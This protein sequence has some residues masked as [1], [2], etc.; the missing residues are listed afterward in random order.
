MDHSIQFSLAH[1][2]VLDLAPPAVARVAAEA[3]FDAFGLRLH[4]VLPGELAP[5][6]FGD[7]PM[8]RELLAIIADTG[9]GMFD[10][11]A[12]RLTRTSDF[13]P[14]HDTLEA[15]A[16]FGAKHALVFIDESDRK[17]AADLLARFTDIAD[18]YGIAP[19]LE[20]MP[21]LGINSL[22][23]ALDVI[24]LA[25]QSSVGLL[26]DCLHVCRTN[27]PVA[28]LRDLDPALLHY[29]QVC[30]APRL[31]PPTL[32]AIADEARNRRMFPG[33]G[34]LPI[35]EIVSAL[36]AQF[37]LASEVATAGIAAGVSG[38]DRAQRA[39]KATQRIAEQAEAGRA[40]DHH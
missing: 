1:L 36:P 9:V 3:G 27:T 37:V 10:V 29:A 13:G 8:R 18:Q 26:L 4:P 31:A 2:T 20:F 30:D 15:A 34:E 22:A 39:F 33:E 35:V 32:D 28:T 7:T 17:L 6:V 25:S 11:E 12:F 5:P 24:A 40:V 16:R 14:L 23:A 38:L 21:W 19:S